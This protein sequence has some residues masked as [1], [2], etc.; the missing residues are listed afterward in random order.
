MREAS[1]CSP[2]EFKLPSLSE[3]VQNTL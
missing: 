2:Q 1:S 3:K